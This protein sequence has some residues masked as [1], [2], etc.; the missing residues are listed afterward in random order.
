MGIGL[1]GEELDGGTSRGVDVVEAVDSGEGVTTSTGGGEVV[2]LGHCPR[3]V[4]LT[5]LLEGM[6]GTYGRAL[7]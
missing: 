3:S 7:R 2:R 5:I 4:S 1:S 6:K